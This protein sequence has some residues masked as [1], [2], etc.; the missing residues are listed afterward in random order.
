MSIY[1]LFKRKGPSGFGYSS[2]AEDVTEGLSLE[3]KTILV[4]GCNSGLGLET[5]RVLALRGA[6]VIGTARTEA[7]AK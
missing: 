5:M 6:H 4:T 1:S 2:T 3:G 7:K